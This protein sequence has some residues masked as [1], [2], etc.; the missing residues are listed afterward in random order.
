MNF[1]L[2]SAM[3]LS[4]LGLGALWYL[5]KR[6]DAQDDLAKRA[7]DVASSVKPLVSISN[8]EAIEERQVWVFRP[9]VDPSVKWRTGGSATGPVVDLW[10]AVATLGKIPSGAGIGGRSLRL[11]DLGESG[12]TAKSAMDLYP[13]AFYDAKPRMGTLPFAD[14]RLEFIGTQFFTRGNPIDF[15]WTCLVPDEVW[16]A[17]WL[18]RIAT[19]A[20]Q[21]DAGGVLIVPPTLK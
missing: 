9:T 15:R 16:D 7:L 21:V 10:S 8:V 17:W 19:V 20:E 4:A 2:N 11:V 6:G 3:I 12:Y 5:R 14:I 13:G 1:G 18:T